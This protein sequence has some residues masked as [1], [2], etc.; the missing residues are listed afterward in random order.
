MRGAFTTAWEH[1]ARGGALA[2]LLVERTQ[3]ALPA[4]VVA[5][6]ARKPALALAA[7]PLAAVAVLLAL[8][9]ARPATPAALRAML[10][11][12]SAA[13]VRASQSSSATPEVSRELASAAE[14]L[15]AAPQDPARLERELRTAL[16]TLDARRGGAEA[17]SDPIQLAAADLV[18]AALAE[19]GSGGGAGVPT[20]ARGGFPET[21]DASG[22]QNGPPLLTMSGSPEPERTSGTPASPAPPAVPLSP[23]PESGTSAGRWWRR[24]DDGVV[25]A[26]RARAADTQR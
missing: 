21:P 23:T 5:R 6:S 17:G 19:L 20:A 11:H 14:A 18:Q 25:S 8:P 15:L 4:D 12:V 2:A 13:L 10:P 16:R 22:M 24:E 3:R 9:P 26:W 1:E 7:L